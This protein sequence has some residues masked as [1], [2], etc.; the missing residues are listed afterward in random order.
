MIYINLL[1]YYFLYLHKLT[2]LTCYKIPAIC[3]D[4]SNTCEVYNRTIN[5]I[6][7]WPSFKEGQ[8]ENVTGKMFITVHCYIK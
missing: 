8:S 3:K 7:S 2:K 4:L 1:E 5:I 6:Y